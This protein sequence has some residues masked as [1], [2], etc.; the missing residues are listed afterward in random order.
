M[1]ALII[2]FDQLPRNIFR[3]KKQA[4]EY[5]KFSLPLSKFL[6][7]ERKDKKYKFFERVF[8]YLPLQH[9]EKIEDQNL[10]VKLFSDLFS[11]Y[12]NNE[13]MRENAEKFMG[14]A[15]EHKKIIEQFGRYPHRN[16]VLDRKLTLKEQE[17]LDKG[18]KTFGQ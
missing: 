1:L 15:E 16:R 10:C 17:Y 13:N 5:E 2:I 9:S 7:N 18:G 11:D 4:F 6:I 3:K 12:Q 8:I 14:Y